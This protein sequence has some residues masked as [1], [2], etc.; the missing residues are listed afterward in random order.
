M[1]GIFL[2]EHDYA[3]HDFRAKHYANKGGLYAQPSTNRE[4]DRIK[5][6]NRNAETVVGRVTDNPWKLLI[7]KLRIIRA[8]LSD[9]RVC[10]AGCWPDRSD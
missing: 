8:L 7:K 10:V 3:H 1:P 9:A 6:L 4:I 5:T 2:P